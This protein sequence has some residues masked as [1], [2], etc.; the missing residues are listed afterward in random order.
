MAAK[1]GCVLWSPAA[2]IRPA[3]C[4]AY[5]DVIAFVFRFALAIGRIACSLA[6]EYPG[7]LTTF[8][9]AVSLET[10]AARISAMSGEGSDE[11]RDRS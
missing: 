11:L 6:H 2:T 3:A 7:A 10:E 4:G 1:A 9:L 8:R 5:A